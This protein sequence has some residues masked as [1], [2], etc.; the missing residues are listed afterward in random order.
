M[1]ASLEGILEVV[2]PIIPDL[3]VC[4]RSHVFGHFDDM[5][6]IHIC[7]FERLVKQR[8]SNRKYRH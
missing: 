7:V 5:T 1:T 8:L 4:Q 3:H 6:M 2:G